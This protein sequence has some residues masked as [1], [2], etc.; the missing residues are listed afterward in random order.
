MA[1]STREIKRRIRSIKGTMKI[2]SAM[3]L[4]SSAKL[5]KAR[6]R[7]IRTRPYYSTIHRNFQETYSEINNL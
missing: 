5:V 4:V 6:E 1:K 2:T 3:E 7:I